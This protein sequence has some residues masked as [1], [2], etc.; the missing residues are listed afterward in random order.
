MDDTELLEAV[1]RK[2]ES[3]MATLFDRYSR[4]G[5]LDRLASVA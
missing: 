5:L 4:L 2:D 1:A 3:A